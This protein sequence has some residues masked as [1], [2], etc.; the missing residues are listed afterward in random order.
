MAGDVVIFR[1]D[2]KVPFPGEPDAGLNETAVPLVG[3]PDCVKITVPEK[4]P[5]AAMTEIGKVAVW[6]AVIVTV[7]LG[8]DTLKSAGAIT[9]TVPSA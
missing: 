8:P 1:T 9:V 5:V 2:A 3:A 7:A 4:P 6:P